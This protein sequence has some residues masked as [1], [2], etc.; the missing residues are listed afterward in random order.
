[1]K[2][3]SRQDAKHAGLVRYCT[4]KPCKRGHLA[5][6]LVSTCKCVTCNAEKTLERYR[7]DPAAANEKNRAWREANPEKIAAIEARR[8]REA[9]KQAA[10][11]RYA[12]DPSA[13]KA[14]AKAW[15]KANAERRRV[16]FSAWRLANLEKVRADL[17]AWKAANV[18]H[19]RTK[20][21]LYRNARRTALLHRT[22]AW[23]DLAA[24]EEVYRDAAEF[25]AAGLVV[26]VDHIIPL[27]GDVVSGLHVPNNLRVCLSSVNRSKSN[28]FEI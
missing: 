20:G 5:E 25:R 6:R 15:A 1:M 9:R 28:S 4:G 18:E 16:V 24:I 21:L 12:A 11:D 14:Q 23:A 2:T 8:N 3:I 17:K 27:Q 26:D 22:P 19:V 13:A 10:R 7:A